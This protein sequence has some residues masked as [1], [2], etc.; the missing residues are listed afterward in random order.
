[1]AVAPASTYGP[2]PTVTLVIRPEP[3][4]PVTNGC[5]VPR[6]VM[7]G[8]TVSG[9][10]NRSVVAAAAAAAAAELE[11][12]DMG[13]A[14]VPELT[15]PNSAANPAA[16]DPQFPLILHE[17]VALL[18]HVLSEGQHGSNTVSIRTAVTVWGRHG[19]IE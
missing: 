14:E 4:E 18:L 17:N 1:M 3:P 13:A 7:T 16:T 5:P 8:G 6:S 15:L 19:D 9:A 12:V 10:E 2:L 11:L